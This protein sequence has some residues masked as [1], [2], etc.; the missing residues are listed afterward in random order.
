MHA[1]R[2]LKEVRRDPSPTPR[3]ADREWLVLICPKCGVM[4]SGYSN[5]WGKFRMV[6]S[7]VIDSVTIQNL[8][9]KKV[10]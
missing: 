1:V 10:S 6:Q 2:N 9:K 3:D 5:R 4:K 8:L 7:K